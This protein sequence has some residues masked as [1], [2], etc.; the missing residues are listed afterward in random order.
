MS[1]NVTTELPPQPKEKRKFKLELS[2]QAKVSLIKFTVVLVIVGGFTTGCYFLFD[3]LGFLS[4]SG[5]SA[6][7][8]NMGGWVYVIFVA[9]F[10]LQALCLFVI[11]GNTTLF[12]TVALLAFNKNF[13]IVYPIC[14]VGVW[15]SGITLFWVGRLGGRKLLYWIFG[16]EKVE[17]NLNLVTNKSTTVLPGLFL[18]P[19][20]PNDFMCMICGASKLKF[21]AFLLIILPCRAIEVALILSYPYIGAFFV[22][23]RP[24]Q[25]VIMFVNI[26]IID[27]VLIVLY[28]RGLIKLFRKT[29]LRKQ[30]VMVEKP[31]TVEE[32]VKKLK[33]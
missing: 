18:I 12:I 3:Y 4:S 28:Y 2:P 29:I 11:P 25:E 15:L 23:D 31:Y 22:K 6:K 1:E 9:L 19:F 13:W 7:M 17:K 27:V 30:Y 10:V 16:K 14:L 24:I 33:K 32:E 5:L 21:W 8:G 20:M 26:L